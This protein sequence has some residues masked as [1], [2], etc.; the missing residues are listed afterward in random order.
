M[1]GRVLPRA[2][3]VTRADTKAMPRAAP[4]IAP[5]VEET[6]NWMSRTVRNVKVTASFL[7]PFVTEK[8]SC[9]MA[10]APNVAGRARSNALS[11]RGTLR[12][13]EAKPVQNGREGERL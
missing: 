11:V 3:S 4:R 6:A 5:S 7:A 12:P 9:Q 2:P 13:K 10:R 1:A 8:A